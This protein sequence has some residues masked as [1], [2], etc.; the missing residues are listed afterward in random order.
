VAA[1]VIAGSAR[2]HDRQRLKIKLRT[3]RRLLGWLD[4][5]DVFEDT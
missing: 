2:C 4:L 5:S 1:E 3:D